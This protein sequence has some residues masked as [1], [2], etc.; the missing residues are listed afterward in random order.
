MEEERLDRGVR[1]Q[2]LSCGPQAAMAAQFPEAAACVA[3]Q[4]ELDG[5]SG[6]SEFP[7]RDWSFH[8]L[9]DGRWAARLRLHKETESVCILWLEPRLGQ[10]G[11]DRWERDGSGLVSTYA[12]ST[13]MADVPTA[14]IRRPRSNLVAIP[15]PGDAVSDEE[16]LLQGWHKG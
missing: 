7:Y 8:R 13:L 10:R 15:L 3:M 11:G 12:V 1:Y 16:L 4:M 14:P 5:E 9:P 2:D 6:A